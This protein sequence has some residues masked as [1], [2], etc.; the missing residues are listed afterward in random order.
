MATQKLLSDFDVRVLKTRKAAMNKDHGEVCTETTLWPQKGMKRDGGRCQ[1]NFAQTAAESK[2]LVQSTSKN[3]SGALSEKD[4]KFRT[5]YRHHVQASIHFWTFDPSATSSFRQKTA[6]R[7][8]A[9]ATRVNNLSSDASFV[10]SDNNHPRIKPERREK[11]E[12][13]TRYVHAATSRPPTHQTSTRHSR[14][15]ATGLQRANGR[16]SRG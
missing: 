3:T 1:R 5:S 16:Q 9:T 7:H 13:D 10:L 8:C 4:A 14:S 15:T 2:V 12:T 6:V 11:N